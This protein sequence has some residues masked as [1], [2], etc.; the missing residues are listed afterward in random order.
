MKKT[1]VFKLIVAVFGFYWLAT[2]LFVSPDNYIKIAF[3]DQQGT[4][5]TFFFQKWGFFA[6]PPK[7]NDRLYF[8]FESKKDSTVS[9][10]FEVIEKLQERKSS[11]A[12][13]NSSED[14]LD[15]VLSSTLHNINDGLFAVNQTLNFEDEVVDSIQQKNSIDDRIRKGKD[16]TQN[17]A[18]FVTL[19][20]YAKMVALRN[21]IK[22]IKDYNLTIEITQ[23]DMPKFADRD[24]LGK[25]KRVREKLIFKS[26]KITL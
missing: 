18:N 22:N 14:I 4:F 21:N 15:Y 26:D 12:P 13:F 6:P 9:Y 20:R 16:Y 1:I 7:Y 3:F 19:K 10:T 5:D 23:L 17:S 2:L 11:K 25:E 8:T 24:L